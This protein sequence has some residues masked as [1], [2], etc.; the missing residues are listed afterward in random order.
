MFFESSRCFCVMI[1]RSFLRGKYQGIIAG[2]IALGYAIGPPIGGALAQKVSWRVCFPCLYLRYMFIYRGVV[3]F[4]GQSSHLVVCHLC[5]CLRTSTQASGGQCEE[6]CLTS[7]PLVD[8]L[9]PCRKLLAVDYL[10][11]VLTLIGSVLILLPLIWVRECR[12][13]NPII[14]NVAPPGWCDVSLEFTHRS[15]VAVF[16][17]PC[18]FLILPLGMEGCASAD[19]PQ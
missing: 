12:S 14:I 3:V 11:A 13:P 17:S 8:P 9:T 6:V 16:G 18:R 4:L 2:A 19:C 15:R 7:P 1:R 5:C 10:G